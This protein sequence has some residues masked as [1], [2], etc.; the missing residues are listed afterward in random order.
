MDLKKTFQ[1]SLSERAGNDEKLTSARLWSDSR[2]SFRKRS[3]GDGTVGFE[4]PLEGSLALGLCRKSYCDSLADIRRTACGGEL[5]KKYG[6]TVPREGS[7]I[8]VVWTVAISGLHRSRSI[9]SRH[10][11]R[12]DRGLPDGNRPEPVS[13]RRYLPY[14]NRRRH[15]QVRVP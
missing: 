2:K 8:A 9:R 5:K 15:P 3:E 6:Y 1:G 4:K 11:S 10:R 14:G 13:P 12:S 7:D